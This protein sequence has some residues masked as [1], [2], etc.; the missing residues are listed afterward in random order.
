MKFQ[1]KNENPGPI[2]KEICG[3][4]LTY[5]DILHLARNSKNLRQDIP[6][7]YIS[8]LRE[9]IVLLARNMDELHFPRI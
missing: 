4:F 2:E 7:K 3:H 6:N 9:C 8:N 5:H 1:M